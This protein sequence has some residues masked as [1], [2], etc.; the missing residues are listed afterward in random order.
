MATRGVGKTARHGRG[1]DPMLR[2]VIAA[3]AGLIAARD[4]Y[5]AGHLSRVAL[6]AERIARQLGASREVVSAV[7]IAGALH[8][9]GKNGLSNALLSQEAALSQDQRRLIDE[10]VAIAVRA[11]GELP[12][13]RGVLTAIA[14]HHERLDGSGYPKG[15][16]GDEIAAESRILAVADTVEAMLHA[17][18]Y[19]PA[20]APEAVVHELMTARGRTLDAA[21]V[22][23]AL[24]LL[25]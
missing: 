22:D 14:Q 6:F 24:A 1:D 4:P 12:L 21:A 16:A 7:R 10:H 18:P 17:R 23:A 13:P 19:R 3:L 25:R 5:T 20:F 9:I 15:L 11:L 2:G 8:D